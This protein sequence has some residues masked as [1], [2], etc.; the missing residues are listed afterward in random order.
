VDFLIETEKGYY[1]F[2]IK[3][4]SHV[5]KSDVRHLIDL[6][7]I[8]DKPILQRIILSNDN[9][10]RTFSTNIHAIPAAMFLG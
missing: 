9:Q 3:K 6:D 2:E 1:A 10:V 5:N 8:L 7:E 4:T